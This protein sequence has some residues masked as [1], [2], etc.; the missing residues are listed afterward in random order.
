MVGEAAY[1]AAAR[2]QKREGLRAG[3]PV[4]PFKASPVTCVEGRTSQR[5]QH[6]LKVPQAG[7]KAVR[8]TSKAARETN[9]VLITWVKLKWS[10]SSFS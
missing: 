1:L 2:K 6:L 8:N 5:G 9:S 7:S 10:Y 4:S 3:I